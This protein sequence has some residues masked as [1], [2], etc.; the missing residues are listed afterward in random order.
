MFAINRAATTVA[1]RAPRAWAAA[2]PQ[3]RWFAD[4]A[5][6]PVERDQLHYDVVCVGG[7][8]AG[9]SAAIRIKQLAL[10]REQ[11]LS[12]CVVEK[13]GELGA[14]ILSGNVF[15]TRGLDELFPDWREMGEEGPPIET[16]V[17]EDAFLFLSETQSLQ[18]PNFVLPPQL[19]N[20]ER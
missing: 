13:G 11:E 8:P 4:E 15:E 5:E 14:H 12:V 19:H 1:R 17:K 20:G 16:E 6:E 7:G 10:E 9:L 2:T 3:M 18:I